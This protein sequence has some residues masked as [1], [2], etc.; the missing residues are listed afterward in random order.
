LAQAATAHGLLGCRR[1]T[2]QLKLAPAHMQGPQCFPLL[3]GPDVSLHEGTT[4][5]GD[6]EMGLGLF[7]A[8]AAKKGSVVMRS[9]PVLWHQ[10]CANTHVAPA[11]LGCGILLGGLRALVEWTIQGR[12]DVEALREGLG[13]KG[14]GRISLSALYPDL[15]ESG[16]LEDAGL[17][18]A[19]PRPCPHEC[20]VLFCSDACRA[21]QLQT[22]H[23]RVLCAELPD[24]RR[25]DWAVFCEHAAATYEIFFPA[26]HAIAQMLCDA[27]G[28]SLDI[29]VLMERSLQYASRPWHELIPQGSPKRTAKVSRRL[30]EAKTSLRLLSSAL[31]SHHIQQLFDIKYY[32]RLLGMLELTALDLTRSHPLEARLQRKLASVAPSVKADLEKVASSWRGADA[33]DDMAILPQFEGYGFSPLVALTNHS[34]CPNLSVEPQA[35]GEVVAEAL[36]DV[37]TGEQLTMRYVSEGLSLRKRQ[38]TLWFGWGFRC[39]CEACQADVCCAVLDGEHEELRGSRPLAWLEFAASSQGV[40]LEQAARDALSRLPLRAKDGLGKA[41]RKCDILNAGPTNDV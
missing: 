36:R 29:G 21:A 8:C 39:L 27:Q 25:R 30:K 26:A 33:S 22:G 6:S 5:R 2:G 23:H 40:E 16:L 28:H 1:S 32:V 14:G 10:S 17:L 11:C 35:N 20:G 13:L 12:A 4:I 18:A 37:V 38:T 19:T 31:D 3:L 34:C 15:V 9:R 24:D 41:A 7:A